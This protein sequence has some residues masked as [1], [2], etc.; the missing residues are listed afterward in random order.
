MLSRLH[1][2]PNTL[3]TSPARKEIGSQSFILPAYAAE[4]APQLISLIQNIIEQ[5]PL[6][7]MQTPRGFKM[8]ALMS[9]CGTQGWVT[10]RQGYRYQTSD[11]L[12]EKQWPAMP[13]LMVKLA[14]EAAAT[15][16]FQGFTPD[17]C[18]INCYQ[19]GAGM[20]LHQDKDEQDFSQPIVSISLGAPTVFLF[21]GLKR[22]DKADAYLLSHGDVVVWGGVDRLRFHGVKPLKLFNHPLTGQRRFNLTLRR[23]K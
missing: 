13:E 9:N 17:A 18:L 5:A 4:Q 16:G 19:P 21:G 1:A 7:Q 12:T 23:A 2:C 10:D 6:R 3:M 15:C 20:G 14:Y 8:A 22:S 11:P